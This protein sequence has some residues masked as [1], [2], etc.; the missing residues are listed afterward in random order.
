MDLDFDQISV[1]FVTVLSFS[2]IP[3]TIVVLSTK[4]Y[5]LGWSVELTGLPQVKLAVY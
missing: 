3:P 1:G 2:E 5:H 4:S